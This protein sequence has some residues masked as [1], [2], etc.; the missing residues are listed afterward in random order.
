MT[1][2]ECHYLS[3]CCASEVIY[4][5]ELDFDIEGA[6]GICNSCH[7]YTIFYDE[8]HTP[9][10]PDHDCEMVSMCCGASPVPELDS[11][12]TGFCGACHDGTG[13]ECGVDENCENNTYALL[14][15]GRVSD[16]TEYMG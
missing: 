4:G 5:T 9:Q 14:D 16:V 3:I 10:V 15:N 8:G 6:V 13:F 7:E 1:K 2:H 12:L 11:F